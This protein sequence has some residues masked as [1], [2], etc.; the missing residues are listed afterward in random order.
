MAEAGQ[1]NIKL[2]DGHTNSALCVDCKTDGSRIISGG[3]DGEVCLWERNGSLLHKLHSLPEDC[4]SVLFS[5]TTES[6]FYVATGTAV[7]VFDERSLQQS[8]ENYQFNEEEINQVVLDEK[9]H[10]L[11]ACD[12]TGEVKII[13]LEEKRLYKTLRRKH[14]NICAT[15]CFRYKKPWEVFSGGMDCNLIHWDF[16]RPKCIN[17]FNMQELQDA[18][19]DLGA[20]M[21]NPPFVHH[22]S[23]SP[24]GKYLACAL[25]NGFVS[26]FDTTKKNIS[27][28]FT[29][30]AHTQGVS[31][32]SF[33]SDKKLVTGGNDC[34]IVEW[35]LEQMNAGPSQMEAT[36]GH[37]A[38]L[39]NRNAQI[40][41]CCRIQEIQH[42][43][44]INWLKYFTTGDNGFVIVADQS[45][46]LTVM[47]LPI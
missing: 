38:G 10:Y 24:D 8:V 22:L 31:Q 1:L 25:E 39:H 40:S 34:V 19:S 33:I 15:V 23:M 27:E 45:S 37:T 14:T 17:Q 2:T 46:E 6:L 32:V 20:Y 7:K 30:H 4:T 18:P 21:V 3:E 29:L 5:R 9:E 11:A 13:S 26:V 41:E 28:A 16:S 47:P 43:S 35:D 36:N 44:K 42:S 12:D